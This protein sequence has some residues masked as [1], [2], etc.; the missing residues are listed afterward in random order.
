MTDE[1]TPE[2]VDAATAAARAEIFGAL[3]GSTLAEVEAESPDDGDA[4]DGEDAAA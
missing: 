2:E 4:T 3:D 1:Q